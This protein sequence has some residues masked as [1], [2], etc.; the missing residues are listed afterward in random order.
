MGSN[1]C[2]DI[3]T[4]FGKD[5]VEGAVRCG[6]HRNGSLIPT[7]G[8]R[9]IVLGRR[10]REF[11]GEEQVDSSSALRHPSHRASCAASGVSKPLR[12]DTVFSK[13]TREADFSPRMNE[14]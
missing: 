9:Y 8:V 3:L 13:G 6:M 11:V 7:C 5:G 4:E 12:I 2:V 1:V 10:R 14:V